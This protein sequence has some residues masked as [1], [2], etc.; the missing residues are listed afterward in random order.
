LGQEITVRGENPGERVTVTFTKVVDPACAV[1]G[2]SY[3]DYGMKYVG[4]YLRIV[5]SGSATYGDSL[6]NCTSGVTSSGQ[7]I[8]SWVHP[9]LSE[10]S[11]RL[12]RHIDLKPG[13]DATGYVVI[14]IPAGAHLTQ[15]NFTADSG[16]GNDTA[17]WR[18]G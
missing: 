16:F 17:G 3:L 12:L 11:P 5:N 4:L 14:E 8:G 6:S 10:G 7:E 2:S 15:I 18:V 9:V 1:G 13:D